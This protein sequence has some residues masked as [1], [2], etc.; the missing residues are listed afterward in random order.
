MREIYTI[1]DTPH[2]EA[3]EATDSQGL[4]RHEKAGNKEALEVRKE[5][6]VRLVVT[7]YCYR[8]RLTPW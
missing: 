4:E 5:M 8:R 3:N 2:T 7:W 6:A 1:E